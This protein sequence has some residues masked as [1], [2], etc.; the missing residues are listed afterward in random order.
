MPFISEEIFPSAVSHEFSSRSKTWTMEIDSLDFALRLDKEDPLQ[1][2]RKLFN[3]PKR[4]N[5]T[6]GKLI[7]NNML[8]LFQK[9]YLVIIFLDS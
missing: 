6:H 7:K 3:Y 1:N 4:K 5:I 8:F 2:F 9:T